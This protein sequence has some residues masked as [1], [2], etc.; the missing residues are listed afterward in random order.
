MHDLICREVLQYNSAC[1]RMGNVEYKNRDISV[2]IALC[3]GL[4][5]RGSRVQYPAGAA[6]FFLHH[7]VQNGSE[8]H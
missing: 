1:R 6:T 7:R 8:A 3:Y 4:D 2:G 5:D